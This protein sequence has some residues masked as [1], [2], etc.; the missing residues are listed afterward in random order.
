MQNAGSAVSEFL[1][2]WCLG[3]VYYG[4]FSIP[5]YEFFSPS[6][7]EIPVRSRALLFLQF[8]VPFMYCKCIKRGEQSHRK[9]PAH[10][11]FFYLS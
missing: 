4:Y 3:P 11:P 10:I 8:Y 5:E 6:S 1:F 2:L 7:T 9:D